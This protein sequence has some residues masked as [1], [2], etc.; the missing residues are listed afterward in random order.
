MIASL[1]IIV[2]SAC[3]FAY[4]LRYTCLLVLETAPPRE[5]G[6]AAVAQV[7]MTG[8][9]VAA[10]MDMPVSELYRLLDR[11]YAILRRLLSHYP[12]SGTVEQKLLV[13]DYA[14]MKWWSKLVRPFSPARASK[15][16]IEMGQVLDY[17][18]AELSTASALSD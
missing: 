7:V 12:E 1:V 17:F 14:A 16:M 13:I 8:S 3:M 18:S 4:W 5:R 15:A 2:L 9:R 11:D 10:S 6:A